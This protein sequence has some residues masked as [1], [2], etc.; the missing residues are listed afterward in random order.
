MQTPTI[1]SQPRWLLWAL[2]AFLVGV[3]LGWSSPPVEELSLEKHLSQHCFRCHGEEK[4]KGGLNLVRL[5]AQQPLIQNRERWNHVIDL[6]AAGNMPPE[7]ETQPEAAERQSIL[8]LLD[9]ELNHFDFSTIDNPG[10]ENA[11]RLTNQ[12]YNRTVSDLFGMPL[13]PADRFPADLT[14]ASGFENSA[15]TLFLQPSRMERYISAAERI[16][17]TVLP[18]EN[19]AGETST[20]FRRLF[21]VLP[22]EAKGGE[23]AMAVEA[24]ARQVLERFLLR[25]YRRPATAEELSQ[26]MQH[27]REALPVAGGVSGFVGAVKQVIQAALISPKFLLRIER[28]P[29]PTGDSGNGTAASSWRI[30]DFELA[31]R[32]SYFLWATMPDDDLFELAAQSKLRE[33][34]TLKSQIN[35]MLQSEKA[36]TLGSFF[37]AQWL[38][39]RF[40]GNRVRL[41]PIDN[42]W[43][44]DSLMTAMRRESGLFFTSLIRENKTLDDLIAADYTYLNEELAREIYGIDTVQGSRMRKVRL[45]DLNRV[46]ILTHG[47]LMA[48]TSNYKQT[49]PIKRGNWILET[50]LG[51][52][53]PPP[54][55]NAGAFKEE[56]EEN[57]SLTFRQKVELHSSNPNCRSCHSKIDP[58]GFS[59]ENF[60][61]FGRWRDS[62]RVRVIERNDRQALALAS[63]MRALSKQELDARIDALDTGPDTRRQIRKRLKQLRQLDEDALAVELT[64]TTTP[65]QQ[66]RLIQMLEWLEIRAANPEPSGKLLQA[67]QQL[68]ALPQDQLNAQLA[69]FDDSPD[70]QAEIA[71]ALWELRQIPEP[72]LASELETLSKND[73]GELLELLA[74]LGMTES[75]KDDDNERLRKLIIALQK[76]LPRQLQKRIDSLETDADERQ[77]IAQ[78]AVFL[79]GIPRQ[80]LSQAIASMNAGE[81]E[82]TLAI[83]LEMDLLDAG[84]AAEPHRRNRFERKP[85]TAKA[86]LPD[87]TPF[88]GPAGL[89][90][91]LLAR[92][93]EDLARQLASKMLAYALGRQLEYFDEAAIRSITK[94]METDGYRLQSLVNGIVASYPF[95]YKKSPEPT[96]NTR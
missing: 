11:R 93:R 27:F 69:T 55:P 84:E 29:S 57:D 17:E 54:P 45:D 67:V 37:A 28:E 50:V 83:L 48:I 39:F 90:K 14:G 53:L 47:S 68:R 64:K 16:V 20:S 71:R 7:D 82:E 75:A 63:A 94:Q 89:R 15:N 22:G 42:P 81:R 18:A 34:A 44:T 87:G 91:V 72:D 70:E 96:Q 36:E 9:W 10:F 46:G 61:Y 78:G 24:A 66:N 62:Y 73:R 38:G 33:P 4:A 31:S 8:H 12:E 32:L 41:D 21:H 35:Y 77:E 43:C 59:L 5:L 74:Y 19:P 26:A 3:F 58:L 88:Q 40:I 92:H 23:A 56:V 52:P 49:S 2:G 76:L 13:S 25:A 95:Q 6:V 65:A 30:T 1:L 80:A 51:R 79:R 85:I 60:D 86:N